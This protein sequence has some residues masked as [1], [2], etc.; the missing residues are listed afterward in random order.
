M[1]FVTMEWVGNPTTLELT[2]GPFL[3]VCPPLPPPAPIPVAPPNPLANQATS[4]VDFGQDFDFLNQLDANLG[5]VSGLANLG[6]ALAHRL[7]T[8]RGGLFYDPNYGT[9]VR[10]YLNEQMSSADVARLAADINSECLKDERVLTCDA[11]VQFVPA[12]SSLAVNINASTA[13][14]PFNF[15]LS[16]TSVTVTLLRPPVA[17]N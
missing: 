3:T 6:Q 8:P 1:S 17:Q 5:L 9:D 10:A 14:G 16:V 7:E 4:T 2:F 11:S 12:T 15:I 13:A